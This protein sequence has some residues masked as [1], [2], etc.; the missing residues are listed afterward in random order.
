MTLAG[1]PVSHYRPRRREIAWDSIIGRF[2]EKP[3][4]FEWVLLSMLIHALAIV[5][6][7]APAGGASEGRSMWGSFDVVLT[8]RAPDASPRLK[9]D[10]GTLEAP[11]ALAAPIAIPAP[12]PRV[13]AAKPSLRAAP[14]IEP[15]APPVEAPPPEAAPK[16][17]PIVIPPV[18]ERLIVPERPF[19]VPPAFTVPP[20]TEIQAPAP[21]PAPVAPAPPPAAPPRQAPVTKET[22]AE[23]APR[24]PQVER[25]P[26]EAPKLS[27]PLLQPVTP[28]LIPE[29]RLAA[30]PEIET[31]RIE[32][33]TL[34]SITEPPV[35]T[36]PLEMKP[37]P[38]P[39][40]EELALPP[41]ITQP[42]EMKPIPSPQIQE[43]A[44]TPR[45]ET[46]AK[47]VEAP[48]VQEVPVTAPPV[49]VPAPAPVPSPRVEPRAEPRAEPQPFQ[50]REAPPGAGSETPSREAPS[51]R[52]VPG[53]APAAPG[54]PSEFRKRGEEPSSDYDPFSTKN[55]DLD[56]M[57]RRAAQLARGSGNTALLPF[58]MPAVP[59]KKSKMEEAIENARKPDCRTAYAD[60]GLLAVVPLVANE[61]GEG[62]CRW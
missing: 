56:A 18:L 7:G 24:L 54:V 36:Q 23:V 26:V 42:M 17:E 43:L 15:A 59:P 28:T 3:P 9:L 6:F 41:V 5:L 4:L 48:P 49:P 12:A 58:P 1:K 22:P 29:Q 55:L 51:P 39:K 37:I 50:Q 40:I 60:M 14:R 47:P 52:V 31:P 2:P 16:V 30:P 13:E 53:P 45:I 32:T 61:F 20:P 33:R 21:V 57:R 34:P 8:G 25:A 38:S 11:A 62:H 44:P 46:I 27:V 10:R 35:I 19:E